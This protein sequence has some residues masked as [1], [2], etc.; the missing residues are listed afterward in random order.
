VCCKSVTALDHHC[1]WLNTCI[2]SRNYQ[3]FVALLAFGLAQCV[4]QAV[5]ALLVARGNDDSPALA[6]YVALSVSLSLLAAVL[7]ATMLVFHVYLIHADLTTTEYVLGVS[8]AS[9]QAHRE[10]REQETVAKKAA[11]DASLSSDDDKYLKGSAPPVVPRPVPVYFDDPDRVDEV[12]MVAAV[13]GGPP[14]SSGVSSS[15]SGGGGGGGSDS[16]SVISFTLSSSDED[17]DVNRPPPVVVVAAAAGR[18]PGDGPVRA[19]APPP[20]PDDE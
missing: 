5:L 11:D 6:G 15:S 19:A 17:E 13:P 1:D 8:R 4:A 16:S 14:S 12:E 9:L 10:R 20:P 2:G 7:L 18:A 3:A